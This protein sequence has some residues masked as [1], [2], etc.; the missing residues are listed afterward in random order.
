M[1]FSQK[2]RLKT[3]VYFM[4]G[5]STAVVPYS[6]HAPGSGNNSEISSG[7]FVSSYAVLT[8]TLF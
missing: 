2:F 7:D 3:C 1:F 5:K 6:S 8:K 4:H